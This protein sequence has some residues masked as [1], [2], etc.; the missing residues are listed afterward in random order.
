MANQHIPAGVARVT[1]GHIRAGDPEQMLNV[2]GVLLDTDADTTY[3]DVFTAWDTHLRPQIASSITLAQVT[4]EVGTI[5]G[6]PPYLTFEF[7]PNAAGEGSAYALTPPNTAILVKKQTGTPGRQGRGR[8]YWPV[9]GESFADNIGTLD[10]AVQSDLQNA[11][12][13]FLAALATAG[14]DMQLLHTAG[15]AIT[16]PSTVTALIVDSRVATQRRRLRP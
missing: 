7:N 10:G 13:A 2:F 12:D 6:A 3:T 5:T 8:L 15:E 11:F 14:V 1:M 4:I 16:D 9:V